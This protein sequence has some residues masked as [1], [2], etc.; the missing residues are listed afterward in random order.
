MGM[1]NVIDVCN[2][3]LDAA[4]EI[5]YT[6]SISE[7]SYTYPLVILDNGDDTTAVNPIFE[8]VAFDLGKAYPNPFNPATIIPFTLEESGMVTLTV[9]NVKGERV[10]TLISNDRMESGH[11]NVM[12]DAS[13]LASGVYVYQLQVDNTVHAAKMVLNK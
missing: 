2:L 13:D 5:I 8:P 10:S 4:D 3:D 6:S 7:N 9:F 12:F 11:H 1:W